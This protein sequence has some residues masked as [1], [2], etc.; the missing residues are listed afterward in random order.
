[1]SGRLRA[2]SATTRRRFL[3]SSASV[4]ATT[5]LGSLAAPAFSRVGATAA[6]HAWGAV[7]RRI[8]RLRDGVGAHG[9]PSA[10]VDR[11]SDHRQL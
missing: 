2:G 1:M 11:G 5:A 8:D 7:G 3:K 10:Y 9:P 4:P 6:H